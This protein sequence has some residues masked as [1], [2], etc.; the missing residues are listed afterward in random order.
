MVVTLFVMHQAGPPP[1]T[2]FTH[3]PLI[4]RL[5]TRL[6][7]PHHTHY[8]GH[9]DARGTTITTPRHTHTSSEAP[10]RD[11]G[12]AGWALCRLPKPPTS[13]TVPT[14]PPCPTLP[15]PTLAVRHHL[16]PHLPLPSHPSCQALP[17]ALTFVI[18]FVLPFSTVTTTMSHRLDS[19]TP[20]IYSLPK[21]LI[22][23]STHHSIQKLFQHN[24][25]TLSL[26]LLAHYFTLYAIPPIFCNSPP[27]SSKQR[28]CPLYHSYPGHHLPPHSS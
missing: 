4:R 11:G 2:C 14:P 10:R 27:I 19:F 12:A 16:H 7:A 13:C 20:I 23:F 1:S 6:M 26:T 3:W 5:D 15:C 22:I 28:L 9:Q 8:N 17:F 21:S 24:T 25:N 18:S